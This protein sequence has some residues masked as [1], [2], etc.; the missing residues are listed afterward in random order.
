LLRST[1]L[2]LHDAG[3]G[4]GVVEAVTASIAIR[5]SLEALTVGFAIVPVVVPLAEWV[6]TARAIGVVPHSAGASAL[7]VGSIPHAET[8]IAHAIA[9]GIGLVA[10]LG[11]ELLPPIPHALS[12]SVAGQLVT[13][14]MNALQLALG[15]SDEAV[16]LA[17]GVLS[18]G[19]LI[20]VVSTASD[21]ANSRDL[22][23]GAR[24]ISCAKGRSRVGVTA[25]KAA[26]SEVPVAHGIRQAGVLVCDSDAAPEA[27]VGDSIPMAIRITVASS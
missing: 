24:S 2:A 21:F 14:T 1:V 15:R 9:L 22:I 18:A 12:V 10:I 20:G 23:P 5:L 17:V 13:V 4:L 7:V 25:L 8:R 6:G 27:F 26:S 19:G 11:A 3:S 16:P